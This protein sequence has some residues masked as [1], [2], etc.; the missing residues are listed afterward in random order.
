MK[1]IILAS[2]A[3]LLV[4]GTVFAASMNFSDV[5]T[6][7]WFYPGVYYVESNDIMTGYN[8]G[9]FGPDDKVNRAQ[10]ATILQRVDAA[11]I[12]K[13]FTELNAIRL[14]EV[15]KLNGSK[16][17][18]YKEVR[19]RFP[20]DGTEGASEGTVRYESVQETLLV[21]GTDE[22]LQLLGP[23]T[24]SYFFIQ[25]NSDLFGIKIYGPFYDD[26]DRLVSEI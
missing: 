16:W 18:T 13:M 24:G 21:L 11:N 9:D 2:V 19:M 15:T 4:A 17:T 10:L 6:D 7:D 25:E 14:H 22:S 1:K 5:D 8:N 20:V 23:D 26:V 12:S 3:G